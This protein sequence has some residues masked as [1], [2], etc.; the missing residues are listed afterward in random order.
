MNA[1]EDSG[2]N[3]LPVTATPTFER[4]SHTLVRHSEMSVS[5]VVSRHQETLASDGVLT[6]VV[7]YDLRPLQMD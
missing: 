4:V 1:N 6:S 5:L 2:T 3:T 7:T